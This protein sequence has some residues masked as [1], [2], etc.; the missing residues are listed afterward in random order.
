MSILV[1][2][3]LGLFVGV[4]LG[5]GWRLSSHRRELATCRRELEEATGRAD[6]AQTGSRRWAHGFWRLAD[7]DMRN[8]ATLELI[9][10][11]VVELREKIAER[12]SD[13][14]KEVEGECEPNSQN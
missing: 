7:R 10:A 1:S 4:L 13:L 11:D 14:T 2:Y 6:T 9:E 12:L 8:R 3:L 5:I